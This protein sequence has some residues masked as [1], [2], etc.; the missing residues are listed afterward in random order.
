LAWCSMRR[1]RG[2]LVCASAAWVVK[3]TILPR[4]L[5]SMRFPSSVELSIAP[6]CGQI[7]PSGHSISAE[8]RG[9]RPYDVHS[10]APPAFPTGPAIPLWCCGD[11]RRRLFS[12]RLL[13]SVQLQQFNFSSSTSD[14]TPRIVEVTDATVAVDK[15]ESALSRV[16]TTTGL[17]LSGGAKR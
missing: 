5:P 14:G 7:R 15:Y 9:F 11:L 1:L 8:Q 4:R 17:F 16:N 12:Y 6:Q 13:H 2:A 10:I 3:V